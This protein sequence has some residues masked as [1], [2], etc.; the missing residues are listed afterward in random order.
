MDPTKTTVNPE[1]PKQPPKLL[2]LSAILAPRGPIPVSRS[3]WYAGVK[4][5]R[6]PASIP[7]GTRM[8]AWHSDDIAALLRNGASK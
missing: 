6:Y 5:G 4:S 8:R 7:L 3:T 1:A 2:R